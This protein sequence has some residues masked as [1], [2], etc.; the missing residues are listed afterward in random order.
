MVFFVTFFIRSFR[1]SFENILFW[2]HGTFHFCSF[3]FCF[4]NFHFSFF[5]SFCFCFSHTQLIMNSILSEPTA[6]NVFLSAFAGLYC[7]LCRWWSW[8]WCFC[9]SFAMFLV[10]YRV[11]FSTSSPP[12]IEMIEMKREREREEKREIKKQERQRGK[13]F[14][15]GHSLF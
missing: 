1:F 3:C 11:F 9:L 7:Y 14:I 15:V 13:K 4:F 6:F 10:L 2:I 12:L 8:W 5:S